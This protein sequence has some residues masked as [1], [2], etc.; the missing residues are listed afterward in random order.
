MINISVYGIQDLKID[1]CDYKFSVKET[2]RVGDRFEYDIC[3][4]ISCCR[5]YHSNGNIKSE[6]FLVNE[7]MPVLNIKLR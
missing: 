4:G 3:N 5:Y 6:F 2:L 1:I 7:A